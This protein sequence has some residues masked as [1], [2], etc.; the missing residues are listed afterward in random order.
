MLSSATSPA[1]ARM[2]T[3]RMPPP[4]I[5]LTRRAR[6]TNSREPHTREPTGAARPFDRQKVME[7]TGRAKSATGRASATAGVKMRAPRGGTGAA[8]RPERARA[9]EDA[10]AV[11]LCGDAVGARRRRH[12]GDLLGRAAGAAVAIVRV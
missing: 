3:W 9:L 8:G 7:S 2:P 5:F 10:S 11:V 1:A 4:T 12:V 6:P